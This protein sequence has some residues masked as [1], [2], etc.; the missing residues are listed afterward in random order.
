MLSGLFQSALCLLQDQVGT[1]CFDKY[2]QLFVQ[3]Y[4]RPH[5]AFT[6]LP[7]L[8]TRKVLNVCEKNPIGEHPLNYDESDPFDIC[9]ASY[10][11]IYHGNPLVNYISADAVDLPEFKG[12]LCRVTKET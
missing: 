11:L 6:T 10:A 3:I 9:A 2:K 4:S 5:T 8:P 1:V 7:L 12:Q